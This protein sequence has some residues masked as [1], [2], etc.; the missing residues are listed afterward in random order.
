VVLDVGITPVTDDAIGEVL[1]VS[2]VDFTTV[3][4]KA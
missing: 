3:A 1:M 2:D 4:A